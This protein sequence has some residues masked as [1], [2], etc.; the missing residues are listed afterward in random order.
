M[1]I[2]SFVLK[3]EFYFIFATVGQYRMMIMCKGILGSL[4]LFKLLACKE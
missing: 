4:V 2:F 1:R 3:M